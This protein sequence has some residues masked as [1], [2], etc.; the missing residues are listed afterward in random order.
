MIENGLIV[1]AA[2]VY[3]GN[4]QP[5]PL[6]VSRYRCDA[7]SA[8]LT[9]DLTVD[10]FGTDPATLLADGQYQLR[11]NTSL[12]QAANLSANTLLD[13]DGTADSVYTFAFERLLGDI[14]GDGTIS[15][16]G[17]P[18][19]DSDHALLAHHMGIDAG[20]PGYDPAFDSNGD[21]RITGR[22]MQRLNRLRKRRL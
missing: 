20:E 21:G 18:A 14:N 7:A 12:I 19:Q 5:L 8:T 1:Q 3:D 13:A 2:A 6:D 11:L 10:G 17:G 4:A 22:D 16:D 9:I 15:F